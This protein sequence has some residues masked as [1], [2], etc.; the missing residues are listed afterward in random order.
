MASSHLYIERVFD[1]VERCQDLT[2]T[3]AVMEE[4]QSIVAELGFSSFIVTGLPL[5]N[6][7]LEPLVLLSSWPAGWF[8]RYTT[9]D[10]FQIDPVGQNV[11]ATTSPFRWGDAPYR[12]DKDLSRTMMGEAV[13]FG[14][15]LCERAPSRCRP[16]RVGRSSFAGV[17]RPRPAQGS[18]G[19]GAVHQ[20]EAHPARARGFDMGSRRKERLGDLHDPRHFRGDGHHPS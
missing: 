20:A 2:S 17:D 10:Y 4:L 19:R 11:F 12:K 16:Q 1:F 9:Q 3:D 8:E 6:R 18:L 13:E 5:P 14:L 7:P 15:V